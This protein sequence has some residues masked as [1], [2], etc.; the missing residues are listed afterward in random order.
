MP[1]QIFEEQ[2]LY[3]DDDTELNLIAAKPKRAQWRHRKVGPSF[4]KFGRQVKYH[5]S[6]LNEWINANRIDTKPDRPPDNG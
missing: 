2:R 4:L 5:G 6:D 3:D 1:H